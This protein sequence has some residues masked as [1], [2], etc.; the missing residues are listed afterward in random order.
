MRASTAIALVALSIAARSTA[1]GEIPSA[2]RRSGYSFMKPDTQAMQDD[3]TSNPGMLWVME[4]EG[5][6]DKKDGTSQ[7]SCADCHGDARDSMKGVA[8]RYPAFDQALGRPVDLE[9]RINLCRAR[10]QEASPLAY[11]SRELLALSAFIAQQS[12]G[13]PISPPGDPQL[14]PFVDKG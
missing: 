2:E 13:M 11:E 7:K 9:G 1:A 12:R 5:L 14:A 10:H 8:A 3:E 4:G 6:W